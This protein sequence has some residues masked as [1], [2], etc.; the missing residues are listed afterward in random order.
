MLLP[1]ECV[2]TR[3][4]LRAT[5]AFERLDLLVDRIVVT[6]EVGLAHELLVTV[7]VRTDML[8]SS[9]GVVSQ[10]MLFIVVTP[11]K[12]LVLAK[13]AT[14]GCVGRVYGS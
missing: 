13:M 11:S 6:S 12:A 10:H 5:R 4:T 1:A 3:E 8:F 14:V 7:G 2:L 9:S